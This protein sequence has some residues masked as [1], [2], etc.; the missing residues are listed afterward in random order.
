MWPR[1]L[2]GNSSNMVLYV[3]GVLLPRPTTAVR[4]FGPLIPGDSPGIGI[5]NVNDGQNNFP[6]WGD[7]DEISLYSRALSASEVQAIYNDGIATKAPT[8][9]LIQSNFRYPLRY[10][11]PRRKSALMVLRRTSS[12]TTPIGRPIRFPLPP[13]KP[14]RLCRFRASSR[15]CCWMPRA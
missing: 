5:G 1:R 11:W 7:I 8:A 15:A 6:Y 12:E 3:N 10:L 2:D 4:P 9:N 14:A 13:P